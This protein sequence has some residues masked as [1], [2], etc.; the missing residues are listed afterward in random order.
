M[1]DWVLLSSFNLFNDASQR[2]IKSLV[3]VATCRLAPLLC[4]FMEEVKAGRGKKKGEARGDATVYKEK[5]HLTFLLATVAWQ[6]LDSVGRID[7]RSRNVAWN[8]D[9][10][11]FYE[12]SGTGEFFIGKR[13]TYGASGKKWNSA[14]QSCLWGRQSVD[15]A[16]AIFRSTHANVSKRGSLPPTSPGMMD[17]GRSEN[18]IRRREAEL[19]PEHCKT[20]TWHR[21]TGVCITCLKQV[22]WYCKCERDAA[23]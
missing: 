6:T 23:Y 17:G 7:T 3:G 18:L 14:V 15:I 10:L 2:C 20:T 21:F 1:H 13:R 16:R 9:F 22:H 5:L 12:K 8:W 19:L 4:L 11:L